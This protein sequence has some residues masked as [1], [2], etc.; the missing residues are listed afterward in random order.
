MARGSVRN[1]INRTGVFM[2]ISVRR[3]SRS[4]DITQVSQGAVFAFHP[5]SRLTRRPDAVTPMVDADLAKRAETLLLF[6]LPNVS[7]ANWR[8]PIRAWNR[9]VRLTP[10][11]VEHSRYLHDTAIWYGGIITPPND[12][13][14][15]LEI[16]KRVKRRQSAKGSKH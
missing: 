10:P 5:P 11:G 6:E 3:R 7:I 2:S 8:R 16:A 13:S 12:L 15:F 4:I 1:S 14:C 9:E